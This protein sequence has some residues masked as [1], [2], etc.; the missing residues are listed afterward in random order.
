VRRGK[1]LFLLLMLSP[2]ADASCRKLTAASVKPI[3]PAKPPGE[4]SEAAAAGSGYGVGLAREAHFFG[5]H[6]QSGV[7]RLDRAGHTRLPRDGGPP[8]GHDGGAR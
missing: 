2:I 6:G 7:S 5:E 3:A 1:A 4:D 8:D